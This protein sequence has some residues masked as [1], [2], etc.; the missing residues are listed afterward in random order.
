MYLQLTLQ[1][2][3]GQKNFKGLT[4]CYL[5]E[6]SCTCEEVPWHQRPCSERNEESRNGGAR[7]MMMGHKI[8][9][10]MG[11]EKIVMILGQDEENRMGQ[12][13]IVLKLGQ[14]EENRMGQ[15][16]SLIHI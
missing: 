11:Q 16:L 2:C 12:D 8:V 7:L 6:T 9:K 10:M 1:K 15:D 4:S 14:D 13:K 5:T 3:R